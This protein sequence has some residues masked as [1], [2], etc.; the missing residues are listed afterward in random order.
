MIR[1]LKKMYR[2]VGAD[3]FEKSIKNIGKLIA[4]A[5]LFALFASLISACRQI[6]RVQVYEIKTNAAVYQT[7][8][9]IQHKKMQEVAKV[10]RVYC[11]KCGR[12]IERLETYINVNETALCDECYMNMSTKEFVERLGGCLVVKE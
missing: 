1:F 12:E 7:A 5:L 8:E 4:L 3:A 11:D 2:R 10:N 9:E 6:S